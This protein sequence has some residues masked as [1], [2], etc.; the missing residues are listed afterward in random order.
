M[1][2]DHVVKCNGVWYEA[3]E[4]VPINEPILDIELQDETMELPFSDNEI[5]LETE[6]EPRK[7]TY[8]DL[9]PMTAKEIRKLAE[10]KG[11][12]ITKSIKDDIIN[13]FMSKQ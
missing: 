10:N 7:Y 2:Y 5:E 12:R 1:K 13:E 3:W 11:I 8:E 4:E 9:E 6:S